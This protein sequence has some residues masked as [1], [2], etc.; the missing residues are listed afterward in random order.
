MA[1]KCTFEQGSLALHH[2]DSDQLLFDGGL[3][4]KIRSVVVLLKDIYEDMDEMDDQ[5]AAIWNKELIDTTIE[6]LESV[7]ARSER[8]IAGAIEMGNEKNREALKQAIEGK[9]GIICSEEEME[10]LAKA[11]GLFEDIYTDGE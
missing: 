9:G 5:L 6:G 8:G 10:K 11:M 3:V 1:K 4:G 7:I 2:L